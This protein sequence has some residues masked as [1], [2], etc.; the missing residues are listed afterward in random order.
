MDR[1]DDD[2]IPLYRFE[3]EVDYESA[4]LAGEPQV[5]YCSL[6]HPHHLATVADDVHSLLKNQKELFSDLR[7]KYDVSGVTMFQSSGRHQISLR[8]I[9]MFDSRSK[10]Y[11]IDVFF[12]IVRNERATAT[13]RIEEIIEFNNGREAV[14]TASMGETKLTFF[15]IDYCLNGKKYRI[16]ECYPFS[17]AALCY[18]AEPFRGDGPEIAS[19]EG[20]YPDDAIFIA[21]VMSTPRK[22]SFR[23]SNFLIMD[24][25]LTPARD[26][27]QPI[28]IPLT[29]STLYFERKPR[30][31]TLIRGRLWL[32]G[33]LV[34]K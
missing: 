20:R 2:I 30:K 28:V 5:G 4:D 33:K 19:A 14:I 3:T 11:M 17:L 15:D 8:A 16:G 13:L 24:V 9:A 7:P 1:I 25:A 6:D 22:T 26:G 18:S 10:G 34:N 27:E 32:Q 31:N 23:H 21:N 12:P 29:V